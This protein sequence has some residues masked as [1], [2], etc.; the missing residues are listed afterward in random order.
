MGGLEVTEK[1]VWARAL[2]GRAQ[3]LHRPPTLGPRGLGGPTW[4]LKAALNRGTGRSPAPTTRPSP[5]WAFPGSAVEQGSGCLQSGP[6]VGLC[7]SDPTDRSP[8]HHP[9]VAPVPNPRHRCPPVLEYGEQKKWRPFSACLK[10]SLGGLVLQGTRPRPEPPPLPQPLAQGV[11]GGGG[12][13]PTCM[14]LCREHL[15][16]QETQPA[17]PDG[18]G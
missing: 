1:G 18:W 15:F 16:R 10:R 11:Q 9:S 4:P 14:H 8:P 2:P 3:W 7:G 17:G 6:L 13:S 12:P 5:A